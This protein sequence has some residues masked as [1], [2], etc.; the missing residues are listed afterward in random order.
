MTGIDQCVLWRWGTHTLLLL[1][2]AGLWC[3]VTGSELLY[4]EVPLTT[5]RFLTIQA[6]ELA[7]SLF[8]RY[9]SSVVILCLWVQATVM[10]ILTQHSRAARSSHAASWD[11]ILFMKV[12]LAVGICLN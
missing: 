1:P 7:E 6:V 8:L 4:H 12:R 3:L 2:H 10:W 5:T 9:T 11:T